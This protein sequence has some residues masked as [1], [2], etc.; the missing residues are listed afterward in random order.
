MVGAG[1]LGFHHV[2]IMRELPD[3]E[4]IG[5]FESRPERA[6]EVSAELGVKAWDGVEALIDACD[7]LSIVVPTPAHHKVARLALERGKH[8]LIE[9][10]LTTT[11]E[12]ADDLLDVATK[13]GALIQTGHVERFNRAIRAALP[14]V[15][16]PASSRA[17]ASRRST[18]V[19]RMSRWCWT[20]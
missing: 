15:D 13:S 3:V 18:R 8:L 9:K 19:G 5:F 16:R 6:A 12:E 1:A 11:L 7:A 20:S 2:R 17:I 4:F 14:Y 10:P